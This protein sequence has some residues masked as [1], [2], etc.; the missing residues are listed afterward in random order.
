MGL[1]DRS[2]Q[3]PS[4]NSENEINDECLH[5]ERSVEDWLKQNR[6]K[7]SGTDKEAPS[8]AS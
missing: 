8:A 6:N 5:D 2:S 4:R 3:C 1:V 7:D